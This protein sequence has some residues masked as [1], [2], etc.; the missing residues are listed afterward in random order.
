MS[1][2]LKKE[3]LGPSISEMEVITRMGLVFAVLLLDLK[4]GNGIN[5]EVRRGV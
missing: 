3:D 5:Y 2:K 4:F 1:M